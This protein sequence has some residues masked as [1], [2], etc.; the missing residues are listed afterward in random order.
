[1]KRRIIAVAVLAAAAILC[2]APNRAGEG[3]AM[4]C[5]GEWNGLPVMQPM[6]PV[7]LAVARLDGA[8]PV[9]KGEVLVCKPVKR[10]VKVVETDGAPA[11]VHEIA[12]DCGKGKLYAVRGMGFE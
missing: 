3:V 11:V 6:T 2:A 7:L 5:K 12:L 10:A 8:P 1:M 9:A 4:V